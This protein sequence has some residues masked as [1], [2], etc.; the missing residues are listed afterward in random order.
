VIAIGSWTLAQK[1]FVSEL[2]G[3]NLFMGESTVLKPNWPVTGCT[4]AHIHDRT[5]FIKNPYLRSRDLENHMCM[6]NTKF[7]YQGFARLQWILLGTLGFNLTEDAGQF[8]FIFG[9][10]Y[11]WTYLCLCMLIFI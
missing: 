1:A 5:D 7:Q 2:L 6:G 4:S 9:P 8:V 10:G 3:T 11:Y